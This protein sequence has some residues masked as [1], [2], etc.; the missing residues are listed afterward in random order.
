VGLVEV[1]GRIVVQRM[2][3][4][5]I[6]AGVSC[7]H[8]VAGFEKQPP[9]HA[10]ELFDGLEHATVTHASASGVCHT[11]EQ[12]FTSITD[13]NTQAIFLIR[14]DAYAEIDWSAL[15]THHSYY[16]NR[17]TRAWFPA[18]DSSSPVPT[19]IFLISANRRND[20]AFLL[21]SGLKQSRNECV[22]YL[23]STE[24][25]VN[26]LRHWHDL[27]QL[28]TDALYRRCK[29]Q[30][31]GTEVRPGIWLGAGARV[32]RGAR[33]VA[34]V[35]V[36]RRGRVLSGA[37][38][39][40]GTSI[41]QH[42]RVDC[43]SIVENA[44]I[45]PYTEIGPGLDVSHSVV[46]ESRLFHLKRNVAVELIDPKL[47]KPVSGNAAVRVVASLTSLVTFIPRQIV[48]GFTGKT[49][50]VVPVPA[51]SG[52]CA[53]ATSTAFTRPVADINKLEA[54]LAVVRRYGN[55]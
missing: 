36:G 31:V 55:E 35:Y 13:A 23:A 28:A 37:V 17:L 6:Q 51:I 52:I 8:V 21:R 43:G 38:V 53:E 27:R 10:K 26:Q 45:Q 3:D 42:S 1:L 30:P 24:E 29:L 14:A 41:E 20:A 2:V 5:L 40:R 49:E 39:T 48:R 47:V 19:D 9:S 44:S 7:V 12:V 46:S 25:Y 50:D 15:A 4:S 11:A 22:R 34:P 18:A 54:G 33:L 16:N 32:E